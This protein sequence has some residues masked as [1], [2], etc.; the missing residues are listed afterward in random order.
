MKLYL[1][2]HAQSEANVGI[3]TGNE[4]VLTNTGLEQAKRLGMYFKNKHL[5]KVYCSKMIRAI[6]TFKEIK[7]YIPKIPITYTKKINER[8]KG[9]YE[10]KEKEFLDVVKKSGLREHEFRPEKGENLDD[11]EKRALKFIDYLKK[12]HQDDNILLVAHGYFL[13][14]LIVKLFGFHIKEIQYFSLHNAGVSY[15]NF[16]KRNKIIS[17]EIDDYK[18]LLLYSSYPR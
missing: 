13:R 18:H 15:F 12:S 11:L 16:D 8:S 3:H 10:S 7:P 4:T 5:T 9:I 1:V 14:V 17:F 6:D 2:R